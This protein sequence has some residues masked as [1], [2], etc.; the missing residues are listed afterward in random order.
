V[1]GWQRLT[2]AADIVRLAVVCGAAIRLGAGDVAV[3]LKGLLV[4]P[5][6]VLG[7]LVRINPGYDLLFT[8]ALAG[9]AT[10]TA[11]GAYDSVSW[12]DTLS[13]LVL[14]LLSGPVLYVGLVR[15]VAAPGPSGTP[16]TRFLLGAAIITATSVLA[17][18]ALWEIVE[19]AADGTFGT[20][21]SQGYRD[22]LQDLL[23]DAIAAIA[24]GALVAGWLRATRGEPDL[25]LAM[26][27]PRSAASPRR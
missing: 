2:H 11:L 18:G 26:V 1:I 25:P 15:L 8:F 19:W 14:P 16:S 12:G 5:P 6:S 23:A 7:R 17:L 21:Y 20:N 22:T 4:L 24:G 10:A 27:Q 3:A 9:E 13:H